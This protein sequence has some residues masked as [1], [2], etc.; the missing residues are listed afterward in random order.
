MIP[1]I[2]VWRGANFMVKR[3]GADAPVAAAQRADA[4][5]AAG[6]TEGHFV[7]ERILTAIGELQRTT[8]SEPERVN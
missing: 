7:W 6:D 8:P 3:H 2:D 1:D 5:L 4:L